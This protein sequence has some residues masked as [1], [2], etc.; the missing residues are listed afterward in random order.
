MS[1]FKDAVPFLKFPPV[2]YNW[3]INPIFG[4]DPMPWARGKRELALL[5]ARHQSKIDE[6][7]NLTRLA[8][9]DHRSATF[10]DQ[11]HPL[12]LNRIS[13]HPKKVTD[14]KLYQKS[15]WPEIAKNIYAKNRNFKTIWWFWNIPGPHKTPIINYII[16]KIGSKKSTLILKSDFYAIFEK[17]DFLFDFY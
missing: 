5:K 15:H 10:S 16:W 17:S 7:K 9:L 4:A 1:I 12:S 8:S 11:F 3:L 14:Q 13:I 2:F 6:L